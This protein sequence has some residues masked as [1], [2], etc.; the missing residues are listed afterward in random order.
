MDKI[1]PVYPPPKKKTLIAWG[2]IKK[3]YIENFYF[4]RCVSHLYVDVYMYILRRK[5]HISESITFFPLER[6]NIISS[7]YNF[8]T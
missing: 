7:Q 6:K 5:K 4:I 3:I 8:A 1:I 2:R